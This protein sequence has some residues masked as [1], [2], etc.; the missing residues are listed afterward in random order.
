MAS[1]VDNQGRVG[2]GDQRPEAPVT[3]TTGRPVRETSVRD[4]SQVMTLPTDRVRWGPIWAGL[5]SAFFTLLVL[6]L[7]GLA[8]GASTV[9]AGQAAQGT[10]TQNAGSYS[11]IWAG[12]SAIIA[13][14]IGGYVAGRTAAVHERGWAALNGA[15]VFLLALPILLWLASQGLGALI[16]NANHIAGGLGINLGQLGT[17]ATGAAKTITPAQAQQA[18]DTARNTAWGTLIGLLLGCAAAAL[19]G[20]LGMRHAA[21]DTHA[22]GGAAYAGGAA[23]T[24]RPCQGRPVRAW[25]RI[26]GRH[27]RPRETPH[28][29]GRR[30]DDDRSHDTATA[31]PR[32]GA[33]PLARQ[34]Q[35]RHAPGRR[36]P[37]AARP[38]HRGH[39]EQPQH[40][41]EGHRRR[42]RLDAHGTTPALN[43]SA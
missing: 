12:I 6:S 18:A 38:G 29:Q 4:V 9:N 24:G 30:P 37:G 26:R 39:D 41:P 14:L 25:I 5:L 36:V 10:G 34:H 11:A 3:A 35:P 17:T 22:T 21:R 27:T 1:T 42:G 28:G 20:T 32:P 13:F 8:I 33:L 19:G 40:L 7:L 15:L 31:T 16:G 23:R 43:G 2:R